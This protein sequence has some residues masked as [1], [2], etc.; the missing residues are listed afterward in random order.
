MDGTEAGRPAAPDHTD[1]LVAAQ[2]ISS[3][4]WGPGAPW[5]PGGLAWEFATAQDP[6]ALEMHVWD[7]VAWAR[8][9]QPDALMA[10]VDPA[11]PEVARD[12]VAW[13]ESTRTGSAP[14][15]EVMD[16]DTTLTEA[17]RARGYDE[18][19]ERFQL[20]MRRRAENVEVAMPSGYTLCTRADVSVEQRVE[21]HRRS[22]RPAALPYPTEHRPD[23]APD[24]ASSFTAEKLARVEALAL[25]APERDFVV[26]ADD[27][28]VAA[29]CTLWF[30]PA[31]RSAEI[32]P[33]GVVPEHRRRGLAQALC[34]AAL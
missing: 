1:A 33:L 26:L 16:G 32:E 5:H 17:L 34:R 19:D 20:D 23:F 4:L 22:W 6:A 24:A 12:V 10:Q 31:S 27:G 28:D 15:L 30:D 29:C 9:Y 18:R 3:R 25:Y 7:D 14:R 21:A 13:V 2:A 8:I 11:N